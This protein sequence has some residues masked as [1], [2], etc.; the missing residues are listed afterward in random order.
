[1][2]N[3]W[4]CGKLQ[5]SVDSNEESL[6]KGKRDGDERVL[7]S[8][9]ERLL[10]EKQNLHD[11]LEREARRALQ[12]ECMAQRRLSEAEVGNGQEKLGEEILLIWLHTK[13][14]VNLNHSKWSDI[15]EVLDP[16]GCHPY[17]HVLA[18][19]AVPPSPCG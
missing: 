17:P 3:V 4:S 18:R 5:Q 14:I 16:S 9:H 7:H 1:M 19:N 15:D 6:L 2:L 12:G 8:E 13:P 11:Y 10:S